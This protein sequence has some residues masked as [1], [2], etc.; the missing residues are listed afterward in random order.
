[1]HCPLTAIKIKALLPLD[2]LTDIP[3]ALCPFI[4]FGIRL[5]AFL[6]HITATRK[7]KLIRKEKLAQ[8][9]YP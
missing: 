6:P 5:T 1:M 2:L 7:G 3:A 9:R 4:R 8:R